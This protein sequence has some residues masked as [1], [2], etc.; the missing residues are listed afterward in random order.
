MAEIIYRGPLFNTGANLIMD[1]ACRD[2]ESHIAQETQRRVRDL[3]QAS[4]RYER[5]TYNVPGKWR[6]QIKTRARSSYHE[7]T[8]SGIIYGH[9]LEGIGSRNR[10]TRFKGYFMWRRTLQLMNRGEAVRIALPH[11]QRA[12]DVINA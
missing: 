11:I 6:S 2:A 10:T 1:A 8:D 7:V 5:P 4:F 12:V 3:G 9:W